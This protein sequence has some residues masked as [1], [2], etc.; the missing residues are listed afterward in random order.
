M[1]LFIKNMVCL[2]CKMLVE[3]ELKKLGITC[4]SV[5]L[6]EAEIEGELSGSQREA[7]AQALN[8]AGL[9]LLADRKHVLIEKI[10]NLVIKMVRCSDELP[11]VKYSRY[12][13][14][15]LGLDYTYLANLFSMVNGIT[16]QQFIINHRIERV[17]ELLM[18]D[19]MNLTE[20]SYAM[21]YSSVAHLSNQFRKVT[22]YS[23]SLFKRLNEN[24]RIALEQI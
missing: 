19:E 22:G 8:K 23:P 17:K 12:I 9:E 6:G 1:K 5:E 4:K 10:R 13:S 18:Y 20:I 15:A 24:K 21:N 16:I 7:L 2:R 14:D 3:D 11:A